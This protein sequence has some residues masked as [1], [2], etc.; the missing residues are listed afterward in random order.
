MY[1]SDKVAARSEAQRTP[2]ASLHL[3]DLLGGWPGALI[4]QQ[5][6]R[7]KTVKRSFQ[8]VFWITVVLNL[9][10]AAWL[11]KSGFLADLVGRVSG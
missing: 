10:A 3:M 4:A 5:Q 2:E 9:A 8:L 11:Q 6:F 7:H 1:R